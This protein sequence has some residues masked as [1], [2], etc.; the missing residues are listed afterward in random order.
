MCLNDPSGCSVALI[1]G[2]AECSRAT[3]Q[4]ATGVTLVRLGQGKQEWK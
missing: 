4:E 1:T 2:R 3:T